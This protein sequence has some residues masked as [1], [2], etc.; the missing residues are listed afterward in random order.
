MAKKFGGSRARARRLVAASAK[1]EETKERMTSY[2]ATLLVDGEWSPATSSRTGATLNPANPQLLGTFAA[3][4][5]G[6]A[7]AV[8]S[9]PTAQ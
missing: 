8:L 9:N 7:Q 1:R 2:Q 6:D 4:D 3:A 5:T